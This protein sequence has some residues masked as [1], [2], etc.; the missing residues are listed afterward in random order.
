MKWFKRIGLFL[1][2]NVLVITTIS[3]FLNVVLPLFGVRLDPGSIG[4]LI[5]FC[6]VWGFGGAFISLLL[7][8]VMAKWM[9]GVQIID[10]HTMNPREQE[11]VQ[12]VHRLAQTAGL[13]KMPDVGIY[14]SEDVNAFATGPSRNNS[15]VAVSTGLLNRMSRNEV[16]GVVGHEIAHVANGD[17]VTM[18]LITGVVNSF[19]LFFSRIIARLLASAVD[20]KI[21]GVVYFASALIFDIVFTLLGSIVIAYFSRLREYRADHGGAMYAGRDKMIAGLR[22]LQSLYPSM[23]PDNSAMA[24]MKISSKPVGVMA[25]FSTHP[26]LEQRI[27]RL[28]NAVLIR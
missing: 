3:L 17:M 20:E 25:L 23:T 5:V 16:E 19:V 28:Q 10:P 21:S 8:K 11:L 18:T 27:E 4:G 22:R 12:M 14:D 24:T 7:S 1:M 13:K 26:P 6:G 15:L 2:V 9:M